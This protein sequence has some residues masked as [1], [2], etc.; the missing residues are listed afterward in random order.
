MSDAE[1]PSPAPERDAGSKAVSLD[2][3]VGL[4]RTE[5]PDRRQATFAKHLA[6]A[7][8]QEAAGRIFLTG[9][10][11][12]RDE[13]KGVSGLTVFRVGSLD[14]ADALARTDPFVADGV[15]S[16]RV[17]PWKVAGGSLNIALRLSNSSIVIG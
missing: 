6:W 5:N 12:P 17:L 14:E 11:A 13:E 1:T 9:P 7:T 4:Y 3:F 8:E 10:L 2:L 16:V 15:N